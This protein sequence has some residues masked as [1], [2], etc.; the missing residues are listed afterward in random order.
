M[1]DCCS[2]AAFE[3]RLCH[4]VIGS[5]AADRIRNGNSVVTIGELISVSGIAAVQSYLSG[6]D[7]CEARS[8]SSRQLVFIAA[9]E[10]E[11][12]AVCADEAAHYRGGFVTAEIT[13]VQPALWS[14]L[15]QDR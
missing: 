5:I 1:V 14:F 9:A 12:N 8:V 11:C 7:A 6:G 3:L 4:C 13:A 2:I 10:I 15:S